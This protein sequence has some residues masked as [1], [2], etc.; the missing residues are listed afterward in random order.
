MWNRTVLITLL[1]LLA[2]VGPSA[3]AAQ[4]AAA[5]PALAAQILSL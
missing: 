5:D 3:L 1:V 4:T 2:S